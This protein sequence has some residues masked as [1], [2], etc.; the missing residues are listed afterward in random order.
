MGGEDLIRALRA[1]RPGLP[2]VVVTGS[3]PFG[4]VE[5]LRR[6]AGGYGPLLLLLKPADCGELAAA[7]RLAVAEGAGQ[8]DGSTATPAAAPRMALAG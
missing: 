1:D 7:L 8:Q 4:G 5:E 3:A 2:V 6:H